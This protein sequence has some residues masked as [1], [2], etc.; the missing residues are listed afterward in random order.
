[1][2][3]KMKKS[4]LAIG[5]V[6]VLG[7]LPLFFR[8]DRY[9]M[10]V[11]ILCLVWGV[12]A[13]S[14]DLI[15]GYASVFSFGHLSFFVIGGY[16]SGLLAIYLGISPWLGMV[17]GGMASALIGVL[18]GIPCLRLRGM[19]LAIVTFSIQFI[20]PTLIVMTGPGMFENFN[21][22][23]SYGLQR[24]PPPVLLGYTF[25]KSE[26]VPWY[27]LT[28]AFFVLLIFAI[29]RIINSSVGLAFVALRDAE[30]LAKTLGIDEYRYKLLVFGISAFVAGVM[31]AYYAH[32]FGLI[33]PAVLSLELFLM[34]LVMVLFGGLGVF[35]GATIGAFVITFANEL[36][37][38]TLSWRLV[39]L[40]AIVIVVMI[41]MPKGL[42]GIPELFSRI[43]R[44]PARTR[45]V[46]TEGASD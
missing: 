3:N 41:F 13:A 9:V 36:L 29:Y 31:G 45:L 32:Y 4:L 23:G 15:V 35:P 21:S 8:A 18:I 28:L 20:L 46:K 37:R 2:V 26:L 1:M 27:Y 44:R 17:M 5:A 7:I 22:G 34:V 43:T 12:V 19:Y 30:P 38:P 40:G 14:W 33:S 10:N 24:I 25:S 16:T 42:M 11:L 6:M 39:I